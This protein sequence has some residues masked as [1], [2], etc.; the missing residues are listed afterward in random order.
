MSAQLFLIRPFQ[1][2]AQ[3]AKRAGVSTQ[4]AIAEVREAQRRGDDGKSVAGKYRTMAFQAS[5]SPTGGA[6]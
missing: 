5:Q 1:T 4:R 6:A 3:Q 2:A